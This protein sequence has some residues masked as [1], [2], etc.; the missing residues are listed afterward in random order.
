MVQLDLMTK[1][2]NDKYRKARGGKSVMLKISC[3]S[4]N[5]AIIEYQKD[6]DGNLRRCYLNRIHSPEKYSSLQY[7]KDIIDSKDMPKLR[8][9]NCENL[10]GTPMRYSDGRL[11]YR[12]KYGVFKKVKIK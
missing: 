2:K 10:I 8:C 5:S 11:A 7:S 9:F 4:C 12:L 6:G 3:A 1:F